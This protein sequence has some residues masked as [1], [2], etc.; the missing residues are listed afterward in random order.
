MLALCGSAAGGVSYRFGLPGRVE[1]ESKKL[2]AAYQMYSGGGETQVS[3]RNKEYSYIVFDRAVRAAVGGE[4]AGTTFSSGLLVS[5]SGRIVSRRL[6]RDD[7]TLSPS[8]MQRLLPSG[9][10]VYHD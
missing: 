7:A 8:E 3:F 6:C 5:R 2:S 9:P 10:F 4:M 1:L